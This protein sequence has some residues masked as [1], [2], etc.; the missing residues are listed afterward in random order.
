MQGVL[1]VGHGSRV[2]EGNDQLKAFVDIAKK[3][4][5]VPI[6]E[7]CFLELADPSI[8]EGARRCIEQGAESLAVVPVLLLAAGHIKK[9]IPEE[10]EEVK[11]RYPDLNL[12][13]GEPFG[14]ETKILLVLQQ[15]LE[16]MGWT[17]EQSA[18]ILL[19]GRG[20]SDEQAI[21]DFHVIAS[22]LKEVTKAQKV[23]TAFLAAA[24]PTFDEGLEKIKQSPAA[25]VF[26]VPYLL[27]TGILMQ[28]M[29]MKI[30]AANQESDTNIHLCDFLGFD[31]QLITIL[32]K[33]TEE[34]LQQPEF[35]ADEHV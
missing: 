30:N 18:D 34:T 28:E 31:E 27:F 15:R 23:E 3:E 2:N 29:Q 1:Y 21:D 26:V 22:R 32:K 13:Y 4:I 19:V 11:R 16:K 35:L 33:R 12:Q 24:R 17:H 10:L 7:T 25:H 9:D 8:L 20:S 14:L 6:Q 5:D